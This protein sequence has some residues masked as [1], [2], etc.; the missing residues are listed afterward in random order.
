MIVHLEIQLYEGMVLVTIVI[1]L[2]WTLSAPG[3]SCAHAPFYLQATHSTSQLRNSAYF[4]HTRTLRHV[5][6]SGAGEICHHVMV[7]SRQP[8]PS[9]QG[10]PVQWC[11]ISQRR[12]PLRD[13]HIMNCILY[14]DNIL[15][16]QEYQQERYASVLKACALE[17]DVEHMALGDATFIG[18][19]GVT[20]SGGQRARLSLARAMY[21][22]CLKAVVYSTAPI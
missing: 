15:F 5:I 8:L 14:R 13:A 4:K 22:V 16:G 9:R 21:Q 1:Q 10:L 12:S 19:R 3:A 18:D 11:C 2:S 7:C 6:L 20:L 17:A